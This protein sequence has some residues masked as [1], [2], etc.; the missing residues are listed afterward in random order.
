MELIA[1]AMRGPEIWKSVFVSVSGFRDDKLM[2]QKRKIRQLCHMRTERLQIACSPLSETIIRS[3]DPDVLKNV[4]VPHCEQHGLLR[5]VFTHCTKLAT[6]QVLDSSCKRKTIGY[7]LGPLTY[8]GR[9]LPSLPMLKEL[10]FDLKI[11]YRF[12][13]FTADQPAKSLFEGEVS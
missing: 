13:M 11:L 12:E 8:V 5:V 1:K 3:C 6:L 9:S 10:F 7:S 4:T 2:E